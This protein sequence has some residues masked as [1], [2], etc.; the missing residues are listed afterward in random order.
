MASVG[1]LARRPARGTPSEPPVFPRSPSEKSRRGRNAARRPPPA[2]TLR[3]TESTGQITVDSYNPYIRCTPT[4]VGLPPPT[5]GVAQRA[6]F[7]SPSTW[8]SPFF[9]ASPGPTPVCEQACRRREP[10]GYSAAPRGPLATALVSCRTV[11]TAAETVRAESAKRSQLSSLRF[12]RRTRLVRQGGRSRRCR[13]IA[14]AGQRGQAGRGPAGTQHDVSGAAW[15]GWVKWAGGGQGSRLGLRRRGPT[16]P[17]APRGP[18]GGPR[19]TA[20]G[21]SPP[22]GPGPPRPRPSAPTRRGRNP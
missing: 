5:L 10:A 21:P 6:M 13:S 20:R 19:G 12:L 2:P 14:D 1:A 9:V 3:N 11:G 17:E 7:R 18:T 16:S 8:A 15:R 22:A 4:C